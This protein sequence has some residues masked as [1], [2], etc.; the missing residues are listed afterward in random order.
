MKITIQNP[1]G[2]SQKYELD[3]E[4][5][6]SLG[7]LEERPDYPLNTGDV[8]IALSYATVLLIKPFYNGEQ[9]I[10]IGRAGLNAYSNF[11][12]NKLLSAEEVE[13]RL[14]DCEYKF[15]HN[16]NDAVFRAMD[17]LS[18]KL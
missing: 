11:E 6:K 16:I 17:P 5:A 14:Y 13:E 15:S 4:R 7:L 12:T 10:L 8:Y 2:E 9:Y 3:V 18:K 1:S